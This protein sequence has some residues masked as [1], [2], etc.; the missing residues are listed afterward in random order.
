M[1]I[2]IYIRILSYSTPEDIS[3]MFT[4]WSLADL[5]RN[6]KRHTFLSVPGIPDSCA[7]E[8]MSLGKL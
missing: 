6:R 8:T 2:Y 7:W 5:L 1:T 4:V 3:P